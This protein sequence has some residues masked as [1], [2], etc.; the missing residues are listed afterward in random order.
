MAASEQDNTT[1]DAAL[2]RKHRMAMRNRQRTV[3][4]SSA[5]DE[6]GGKSNKRPRIALEAETEPMTVSSS[7]TV[8]ASSKSTP[9]DI[10]EAVK[11]KKP[12][13]TGIK[14]QSRY[15]P[16]VEMTKEELK[17][18]RKEARR[19]RN[20]E[21]AAASRKKNREAIDILEAEVNAIQSKYD[22]ALKYILSLED[23]LRR[24]GSSSTS[25][26]PSNVLR[27]DLKG[28]RN[29][30]SE[31]LPMR[32]TV[33]PSQSPVPIDPIPH[34]VSPDDELSQERLQWPGQTGNG[35]V[36]S[37]AYHPSLHYPSHPTTLTSHKHIIDN[38]IIRPIACV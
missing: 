15:D 25:F 36:K 21:S 26:I 38:M 3:S 20:R 14:R 22:A 19:V 4:S 28:I 9:E 2:A 16:G 7:D 1:S 27:Q 11:K 5:E 13:I 32:Q 23:Q 8:D 35:L 37:T 33:S 24:S 6:T 12:H 29:T 34:G 10:L 17:A 31:A 18:W 30:A